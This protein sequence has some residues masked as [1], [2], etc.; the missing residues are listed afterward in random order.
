[1][2][3]QFCGWDNPEGKTH[4]EKCNK[5]L[6]GGDGREEASAVSDMHQKVTVQRRSGSFNPK[7]TVRENMAS[8]SQPVASASCPECGFPLEDGVCANCG[9][10]AGKPE[11][12]PA[13]ADDSL[14][15]T[16]RPKRKEA[17]EGTFT[18]TPISEETGLPEGDAIHY[19]GNEVSL[20]RGNTDPKNKTITSVEQAVVSCKDGKW[21]IQ[22]RSELKTTFVQAEQTIELKSGSLILL[23]SQLYRFEG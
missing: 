7:A 21:S 9:Y 11:P 15:R 2:R 13:K 4:C 10:A 22:D 16:V 18:L 6:L 23:G 20:N 12:K 3:C 8:G 19:E 5:P 1:M 17:K 14:H